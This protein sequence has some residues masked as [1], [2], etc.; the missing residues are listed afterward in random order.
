MLERLSDYTESRQV[1]GQ[2]VSNAL[3][4][5][6]VLLVLSFAIVSFLLAYVVPQVV[7][8]FE[9]GHQELPIATRILIGTSDLIRHY[10]FYGLIVIA[11]VDLGIFA[12]AQEPGG[13]PALRSVPAARCRSRA[14]SS[15]V[16][17]P[18]D[19]RAL[20]AF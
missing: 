6:I 19:F 13:A 20:S 3:V 11:A 14:S 5:P 7:A 12:L 16:S 8:V 1:M 18:R 10:W 17:T 4:Y 9:S 15:A 2:Q